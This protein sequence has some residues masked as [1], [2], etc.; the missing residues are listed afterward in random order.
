MKELSRITE[1]FTESVI[2]EMTRICD[3]VGGYNLS[4]GFPDFESPQE[5]STTRIAGGLISPKRA[6]LLAP[7]KGLLNNFS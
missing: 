1:T 5:V 2:R 3:A 7:L 4:Q 6:L